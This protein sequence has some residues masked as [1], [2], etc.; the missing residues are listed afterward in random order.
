MYKYLIAAFLFITVYAC[1]KADDQPIGAKSD[2]ALVQDVSVTDSLQNDVIATKSV[3]K[4]VTDP[5]SNVE[6]L[7]QPTNPLVITVTL[8]PGTDIKNINVRFT[9]SSQS[10]YAKVS[11][12]LGHMGDY[13][14][15]GNYTVTSQSGK[16]VNVYALV[17]KGS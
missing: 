8:K 12:A 4:I 9:L 3:P 5:I 17:I 2:Q 15:G 14:A 11:P 10:K 7:D 6:K 13:S 1:S 16:N